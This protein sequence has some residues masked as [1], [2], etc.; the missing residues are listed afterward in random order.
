MVCV[1]ELGESGRIWYYH[2]DLTGTAQEVTKADGTLQTLVR[3][4]TLI[5]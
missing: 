5:R 1:T 3:L 4:Y 2:T